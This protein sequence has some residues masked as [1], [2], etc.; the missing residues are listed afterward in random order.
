MCWQ[1]ATEYSAC[2]HVVERKTTVCTNACGKVES[3]REK[4][5]YLCPGC[6][7]GPECEGDSADELDSEEE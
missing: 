3:E 5:N 6:R 4:K 1:T 2:G 7:I